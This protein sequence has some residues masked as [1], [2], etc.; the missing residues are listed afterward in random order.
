MLCLCVQLCFLAVS[1]YIM[2]LYG[3]CFTSSCLFISNASSTVLGS[4]TTR[5]R[6]G[7]SPGTSQSSSSVNMLKELTVVRRGSS[8]CVRCYHYH[9]TG[10]CREMDTVVRC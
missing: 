7:N 5:S 8:S 4:F 2:C 6:Q 9:R 3:F 1:V 10:L